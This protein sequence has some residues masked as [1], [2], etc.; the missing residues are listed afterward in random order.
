M[1]AFLTE[2][3]VEVMTACQGFRDQ[4]LSP[5]PELVALEDATI[6]DLGDWIAEGHDPLISASLKQKYNQ[7]MNGYELLMASHFEDK[8]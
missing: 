8:N 4:G 3:V 7:P 1:E 5:S 2:K 6:K